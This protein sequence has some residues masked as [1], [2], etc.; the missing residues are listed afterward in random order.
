MLPLLQPIIKTTATLIRATRSAIT[1]FAEQPPAEKLQEEDKASNDLKAF[2]LF[3]YFT[4]D[5]I[6]E[7]TVFTR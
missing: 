6:R 1:P 5:I 4:A 2:D 7:K 3:S